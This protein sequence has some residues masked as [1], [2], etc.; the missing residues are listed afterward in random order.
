M[1]YYKPRRKIELY[2]AL[3]ARPNRWSDG[4]GVF[5]KNCYLE[6]TRDV[7]IY[8][9]NTSDV[10]QPISAFQSGRMRSITT[11]QHHSSEVIKGAHLC[12]QD[13]SHWSDIITSFSK[14]A[15][16]STFTNELRR[17]LPLPVKRK[18][19]TWEITSER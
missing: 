11:N 17:H 9:Q 3:K 14:W 4:D 8:Q 12:T 6:I 13:Q 2:N 16:I 7:T 5:D 19:D 15:S 18:W 10:F 1:K